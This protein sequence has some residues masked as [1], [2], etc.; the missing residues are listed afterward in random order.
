MY[1]HRYIFLLEENFVSPDP[2]DFL[3]CTNDTNCQ[4]FNFRPGNKCATYEGVSDDRYGGKC[5]AL[6]A[7]KHTYSTYP[8]GGS[9]L[10][11]KNDRDGAEYSSNVTKKCTY[12]KHENMWCGHY[13]NGKRHGYTFR[14]AAKTIEACENMCDDSDDCQ[15][16]NFLKTGKC[17]TYEGKSDD[18]Y[19]GKCTALNATKHTYSTY[20]S[21]G[22]DLYIKCSRFSQTLKSAKK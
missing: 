5:T 17:Y 21:S 22:S 4:A 14:N 12:A 19:G 11:I 3:F 8:R 1:L 6:N 13:K 20:P 10:Y 7:T 2:R 16:F 18:R 9:D 15:A